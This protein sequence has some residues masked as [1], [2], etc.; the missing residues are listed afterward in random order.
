MPGSVDMF[1][2]AFW[3][4][5]LF[6]IST[7]GLSC[8]VVYI[9]SALQKYP[10]SYE[11]FV[12]KLKNEELKD[13]RIYNGEGKIVGKDKMENH[14]IMYL[15]KIIYYDFFIE[16]FIDRMVIKIVSFFISNNRDR[17]INVEMIKS[18]FP[19][20]YAFAFSNTMVKKGHDLFCMKHK[21]DHATIHLGIMYDMEINP[22]CCVVALHAKRNCL[23]SIFDK[24][25]INIIGVIAKDNW[26]HYINYDFDMGK[27]IERG[28]FEDLLIYALKSENI[29][30]KKILKRL[31]T[32]NLQNEKK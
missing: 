6:L 5:I 25:F 18:V 32:A 21:T 10:Q 31:I 27:S 24:T 29:N 12:E 23:V 3:N 8:I 26:K 28:I 20:K 4:L 14:L 22:I 30:E 11:E 1:E 7:V 17:F 15:F 19:K 13:Y 16:N 2:Y 9:F